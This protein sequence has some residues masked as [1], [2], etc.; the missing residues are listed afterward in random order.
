LVCEILGYDRSMI[1]NLFGRP[2]RSSRDI[3]VLGKEPEGWYDA[4][5]ELSEAISVADGV[6]LG[7]GLIPSSRESGP[8]LRAQLQWLREELRKQGH[9]S[10]WQVG[11]RPRHPS[12]WHQYVSDVHQRTDGGSFHERLHQALRAVPLGGWDWD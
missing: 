2:S 10:V 11:D 6:L 4:R 9:L 1:V 3:A 8:H 5:Q 7:F 12:R